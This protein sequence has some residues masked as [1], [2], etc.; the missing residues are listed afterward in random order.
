MKD[1]VIY[2]VKNLVDQP[3]EVKVDVFEGQQTVVIEIRV[4]EDD[5]AR[6]IGRQGNTIKALR[7]LATTVAARFSKK[8][9]LELVE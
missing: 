2:L 3:D 9:R 5:V 8:I 7:A 6:V 1:F 4:A